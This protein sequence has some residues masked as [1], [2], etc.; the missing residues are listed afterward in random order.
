VTA[1]PAPAQERPGLFARLRRGTLALAALVAASV[2]APG[3]GRAQGAA[4]GRDRL[5]IV[6]T[7]D[8]DFMAAL[9][10]GFEKRNPGVAVDQVEML[11]NEVY[12]AARRGDADADLAISSAPD[13]QVKLANDG[14]ARA[15]ASEATRRLPGWTNWRDEVFAFTLEPA[16]IIYNSK[17]LAASLA[18]ET[19]SDLIRLLKSER[20]LLDGR[21][22]TYDLASGGL[23]YLFASEDS[24]ISGQFWQLAALLGDRRARLVARSAEMLDSV[25][26]G[27]S[28]IGYNVLGTYARERQRQGQAIG[29][30]F[31]KDYTLLFPRTAVIPKSARRPDLAARF[32]DY[33]LSEE[34]QDIIAEQ[35]EIPVADFRFEGDLLPGAQQNV[36]GTTL[37]RI[38]LGPG[39][40]VFRDAQKRERFLD[41][42]RQITA[43]R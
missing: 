7:T 38:N 32:I 25:A 9:V 12:D 36:P 11:A 37:Y 15:H 6:M 40:L 35:T 2:A 23:G 26:S 29:I 1:P 41:Q 14:F 34:A 39:L 20:E 43:Q 22:V 42:W 24:Q 8:R 27:E 17:L 5:R 13:L 28:L 18:P 19:R 21:L 4:D 3:E 10:S 16:V 31:P 30:V 33:L